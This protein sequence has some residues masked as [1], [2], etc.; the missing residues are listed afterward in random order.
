MASMDAVRFG[1]F[2]RAV[3]RRLG[4]RQLDV[5]ARAGVSASAIS[6]IER[7]HLDEVTWAVIARTCAALEIRLDLRPNW[8]GFEGDRLLD[9]DHAAI[10]EFIV[11]TLMEHG[12]RTIV[13]YTF[14]HFGD[15]GSVDIVAWH[16]TA[17][18]LL[19]IEVKTQIVEVNVLAASLDRKARVVP[20]LLRAQFGWQPA[21]VARLLVVR[22]TRSLRSVIE[23]FGATFASSLPD[24]TV[25]AWKWIAKPS[26]SLAGILFRSDSR[27]A[28][29][30]RGGRRVRPRRARPSLSATHESEARTPRDARSAPL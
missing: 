20:P 16:D 3:R 29:A 18:A 21:L 28:A 13:E 5:A 12:W 30:M 8:R 7:G 11:R 17:T 14:N 23:K 2:V 25:A 19:I 10:V 15:R 4:L 9:S 6:R 1:R 26:G 22:D 27:L 24:R